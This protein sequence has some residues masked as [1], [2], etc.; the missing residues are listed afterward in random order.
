MPR[1]IEALGVTAADWQSA[2]GDWA[3]FMRYPA[4]ERERCSA[5]PAFT[6]AQAPLRRGVSCN[7]TDSHGP[8]QLPVLARGAVA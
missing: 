5:R 7:L 8:A 6:L 3:L 4:A 1:R 2:L